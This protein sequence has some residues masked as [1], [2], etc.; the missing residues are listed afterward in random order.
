MEESLER[1][2]ETLDVATLFNSAFFIKKVL[3]QKNLSPNGENELFQ[4][5]MKYIGAFNYQEHLKTLYYFF[6]KYRE[7][8]KKEQEE[9]VRREIWEQ[10]LAESS[11]ICKKAAT[12]QEEDLLFYTLNFFMESWQQL[13]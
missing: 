2:E 1:K 10:M 13:T 5:L 7:L 6:K 8:M 12:K 9:M 11:H 4:I 3:E